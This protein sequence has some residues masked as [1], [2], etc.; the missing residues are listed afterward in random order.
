MVNKMENMP[1]V[2]KRSKTKLIMNNNVPVCATTWFIPFPNKPLFLHVCKTSPLKTLRETEKLLAT[3]N[4]S[5]SHSVFHPCGELSAIFIKFTIV[6][7]TLF[8]FGPVR[9]IVISERVKLCH[10]FSQ[11]II[12]VSMLLIQLSV[13][14]TT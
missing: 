13:L 8:Q 6:V 7:C 12:H 2:I 11:N 3:S 5:F 9:N 10:Q 14:T 4:F 1:A